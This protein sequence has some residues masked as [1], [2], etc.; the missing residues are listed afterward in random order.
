[1]H[2]KIY[3][4]WSVTQITSTNYIFLRVQ[5]AQVQELVIH[6]TVLQAVYVVVYVIED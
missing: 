6:A 1:M 4:I 3:D 5:N 2:Y